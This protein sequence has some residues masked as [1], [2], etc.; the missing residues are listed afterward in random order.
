MGIL[1]NFFQVNAPRSRAALADLEYAKQED[2]QKSGL[3]RQRQD[4]FRQEALQTLA[5]DPNVVNNE[6]FGGDQNKLDAFKA[7]LE[8]RQ[9]N[10]TRVGALTVS[11]MTKILGKKKAVEYINNTGLAGTYF[12]PG[13]RL[14]GQLTNF[15]LDETGEYVLT[16]PTVRVFDQDT[17][18]F[19]SA[20]ATRGGEKVSDLFRRGG[21]AAVQEGSFDNV[22]LSFVDE[23]DSD[24]RTDI[25]GRTGGD[26]RLAYFQPYSGNVNRAS[27][28]QDFIARQQAAEGDAQRA[29]TAFAAADAMDAQEKQEQERI[30]GLARQDREANAL[31]N[32]GF[33]QEPGSGTDEFGEFDPSRATGRI[34]QSLY[35]SLFVDDTGLREDGQFGMENREAR[36]AQALSSILTSGAGS[37]G[38]GSDKIAEGFGT[39]FPVTTEG[40]AKAGLSGYM[41]APGGLPFDMTE[42]QF[43]SLAPK[44]RESAITLAKNVSD[45]NLQDSFEGIADTTTARWDRK[46]GSTASE[47]NVE[48]ERDKPVI[49]AAKKFYEAEGMTDFFAT[50]NIPKDN[51]LVKRLMEQPELMQEFKADP[52]AF[53][54]KYANDTNALFG[55]PKN[56]SLLKQ[57][58]AN[59]DTKDMKPLEKA[60]ATRDTD[61]IRE[62]A[63]KMKTTSESQQ[64]E[65]AAELQR[66]G[67]DFGR[68]TNN[69]R[70]GL[71]FSMV[72][73]L[74]PDSELFEMLTRSENFTNMVESGV[75]NFNQMTAETDRFEAETARMK[76]ERLSTPVG[77]DVTVN[78][79]AL[80]KDLFG[81]E[82]TPESI[83]T[84]NTTLNIQLAQIADA[85]KMGPL[86]GAN[87]KALVAVTGLRSEQMKDFVKDASDPSLIQEFLT[88]GQ[89]KEADLALFKSDARVDAIVDGEKITTPEQWYKLSE[90]ERKRVKLKEPNSGNE[91]SPQ[92]LTAKF[93]PGTVETLI[94]RG[95]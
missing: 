8:R 4:V 59:I 12:G 64:Q 14:D 46:V 11:D 6:Y 85:A 2:R 21:D 9:G 17:G 65:L 73:S 71:Y 13:T 10:T 47:A 77:A 86:S 54:T 19:Y 25:Q 32:Y 69:E 87:R 16:N 39:D 20:N 1:D 95:T 70:I 35:N 52:T 40:I 83:R 44:Q 60:L 48:I 33:L 7:D 75:F 76:E 67:G 68:A 38:P 88:L 61:K 58:V 36:G 27:R 92:A 28:E 51:K 89:A 84:A 3:I 26:E 80:G 24:Y 41:F 43:L 42:E 37:R 63:R 45:K 15:E 62:L 57:A 78:E 82:A 18:R 94:F 81:A 23:L 55:P 30:A 29:D 22:P 91:I 53:A 50:G 74:P 31:Y 49:E 66:T 5:R 72:S 79:D 90:E 93:G 56:A 34:G